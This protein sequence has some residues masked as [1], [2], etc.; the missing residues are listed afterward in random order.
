MIIM[1]ISIGYQYN[2]GGA[3][4]GPALS[5]LLSHHH[6]IS[7]PRMY[8]LGVLALCYL[9][10]LGTTNQELAETNV[11]KLYDVC[12]PLPFGSIENAITAVLSTD[13][14]KYSIPE[15]NNNLQSVLYR[16]AWMPMNLFIGPSSAIRIDDPSQNND[17]LPEKMPKPQ[18]KALNQIISGLCQYSHSHIPNGSGARGSVRFDN[19]ADFNRL[20][21][22]FFGNIDGRLNCY[23]SK[24]SDWL[25][26]ST[27]RA[28]SSSSQ[29]Y[30][31]RILFYN[32]KKAESL[33]S[34]YRNQRQLFCGKFAVKEASDKQIVDGKNFKILAKG[35]EYMSGIVNNL[36]DAYYRNE[37]K[38][39]QGYL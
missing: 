38:A 14:G 26:A 7:Y 39:I 34:G 21:N 13:P 10:R 17:K 8:Y 1:Q 16:I 12:G 37:D 18:K 27:A 6:V 35:P 11:A 23:D 32:G 29:Y 36:E 31:Y 5:P 15:N 28:N 25:I 9:K 2:R 3:A 30:Y 19:E 20:M 22:I 4:A 24:I 33:I